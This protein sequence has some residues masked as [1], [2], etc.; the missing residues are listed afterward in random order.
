MASHVVVLHTSGRRVKIKVTQ[1]KYL[2]DVFE[3]ACQKLGLESASYDF[4]VNSKPL[5]LSQTLQQSCLPSGAK[6]EL[7]LAS[8][9][10][11]PVSV[12]LD[13]PDSLASTASIKR[14]TEKFSSS[15]TLWLV[16]RKF[17]LNG[18]HS[19]NLTARASS[20]NASGDASVTDGMFYEM[21]VLNI[22]GRKL[23]SF[24]DLQKTLRQLGFH[25][26]TCLIRL[27]Y[28]R[29]DQLI[30]EAMKQITEYFEE[31]P[32]EPAPKITDKPPSIPLNASNDSKCS[33]VQLEV[34]D[35]PSSS[36]PTTCPV[37]SDLDPGTGDRPTTVFRPPTSSMPQA[38]SI[39]YEEDDFE[40][41]IAHAK[42]HQNRLLNYSR[43]VR[44][45]SDVEI[46]KLQKM[47]AARLD[48]IS[49]VSIKIRYPDQTTSVTSFKPDETGHHLYAFV[50]KLIIEENQPFKLIWRD[51]DSKA[52]PNN[53]KRLVNDLGFGPRMLLYFMWDGPVEPNKKS[54]ILKQQ[55]IEDSQEIT[56]PNLSPQKVEIPEPAGKLNGVKKQKG[57]GKW[58]KGLGK[59]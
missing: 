12:A 58:F 33:S 50:S 34:S 9:T 22:M 21:P 38:A 31:V 25:S 45:P 13:L 48:D 44:L 18:D 20:G 35:L 51:H 56:L 36:E 32:T 5:D 16:L 26:G 14:L 10:P 11:A 7:V 24:M 28:K 8:R 29:T 55:Y 43:N 49:E 46:E 2:A 37:T 4:K 23:S 40:P 19:L 17:E 42:L 53:E 3:E 41:T 6:L 27:E 15:T 1:T 54:I 52:V 59:K 47:K 39:P 30:K 57:V